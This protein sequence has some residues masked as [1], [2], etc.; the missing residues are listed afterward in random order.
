MLYGDICEKVYQRLE[1][2]LRKLTK[3]MFKKHQLSNCYYTKVGYD[4]K[5]NSLLEMHRPTDDT[6]ADL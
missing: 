4:L 3:S 5:K 2:T 6:V 1:L